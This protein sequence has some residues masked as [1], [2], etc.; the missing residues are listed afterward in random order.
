MQ[1]SERSKILHDIVE[2]AGV[3]RPRNAWTA[4]T[5]MEQRTADALMKL[6]TLRRSAADAA[7][8]LEIG[9]DA[10]AGATYMLGCSDKLKLVSCDLGTAPYTDA[11]LAQVK[12]WFGD[13]IELVKGDSK[14]TV[15]ALERKTFDLI[16]IDGGKDY[17]TVAADI[18]NCAALA[19][20][21]TWLLIDGYSSPDV[22]A[23][24]KAAVKAKQIK[25]VV[26]TGTQFAGRYIQPGA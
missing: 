8:A 17:D 9:F 16:F 10:G 24:V 13:R 5:D 23:A 22:A 3:P 15:P 21:D 19:D 26:V 6:A 11:C 2:A 14:L 1:F 7:T 25:P 4:D 20:G 18:T 12:D